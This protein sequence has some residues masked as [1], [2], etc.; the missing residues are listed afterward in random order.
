MLLDSERIKAGVI[1]HPVAHSLSPVIHNYWLEKYGINGEYK[2]YDIAPEN[3]EKFLRE[4]VFE[5]GLAGFNVTLPHK[6]AVTEF[7]LKI[8]GGAIVKDDFIGAVNTAVI[9]NGKITRLFNT[10]WHGFQR[11]IVDNFPY[12]HFHNYKVV[13]LGAGG[14]ARAALYCFVNNLLVA[15]EVVIV[16]RTRERAEELKKHADNFKGVRWETTIKTAEWENRNEI[17]QNTDILINTTS[18]G[19]DGQPS[20]EIDLSLLPE[21]ALVTDI[22]YN[23]LETALLKQARERG[24][25]VVDGLGMLLHQ[26]VLGFKAWF[27]VQPKVTEE[28]RQHVLHAMENS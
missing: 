13:I 19:M 15:K 23:P 12:G 11:N 21:T 20:L 16:N 9:K 27:G 10:D 14:A 17:L 8:E 26:A 2:A 6:V 1:G 24:N 28:L 25:P 3:L 22:V 5:L 7:G 4:D 18:L